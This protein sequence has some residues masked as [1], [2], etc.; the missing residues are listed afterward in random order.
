MSENKMN[1]YQRLAEVRKAVPYLKKEQKGSQYQYVGS[2]DV[3]GA[4][5]EKINEVGLVLIPE[6]VEHKVTIF[7]RINSKGN[8]SNEYLT[9]LDMTMTWVNIDEPKDK[10]SV[11][12]YA[13]GIDLAGEKG[14][15]KA[16]TYGEKYYLLKVFNIATDKD[17][18]DAFQEKV[19]AKKPTAKI[20]EEQIAGLNVLAAEY[21]AL[22]GLPD[23]AADMLDW[24]I[25][26]AKVKKLELADLDQAEAIRQVLQAVIIRARK[27]AEE[28]A[29]TQQNEAEA[30]QND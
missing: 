18:P 15:G 24:A 30:E 27:A 10:I 22:R 7:E 29:A 8:V 1:V 3:L 21:A 5:H 25:K 17:D 13:Q 16:L 11:K 28:E 20:T 19:D 12:W 14:V 6:I 2:A 26:Q 4:L 9:E 23:K